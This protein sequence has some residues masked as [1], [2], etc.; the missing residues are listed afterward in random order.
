MHVE[1]NSRKEELYAMLAGNKGWHTAVKQFCKV[2]K[3]KIAS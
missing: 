2:Q 1:P 3:R